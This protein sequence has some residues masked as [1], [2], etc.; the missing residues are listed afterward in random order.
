MD[1]EISGTQVAPLS[2]VPM[3]AFPHPTLKAAPPLQR[4]R[5]TAAIYPSSAFMDVLQKSI[6]NFT[7]STNY[8]KREVVPRTHNEQEQTLAY[9]HIRD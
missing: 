1:A 9:N 4:Q 8:F 2:A 7:I 3:T 6:N 5:A